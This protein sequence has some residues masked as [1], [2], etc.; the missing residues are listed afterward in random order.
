VGLENWNVVV[1][2]DTKTPSDWALEGAVYL[3][4]E[5]QAA[6]GYQIHKLL[7]LRHYA[8]KN[9]GYLYAI[10][11]GAEASGSTLILVLFFVFCSDLV[12]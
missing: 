1:V 9:I 11:H 8:R 6:L 7:P 2:G 5:E 4:L 3:G 10:Q 12:L